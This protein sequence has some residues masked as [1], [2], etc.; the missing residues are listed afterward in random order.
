MPDGPKDLA[1]LSEAMLDAARAAGADAADALVVDGA[2]L[3]VDVLNGRLEQAERAEGVEIGLRVMV[4][5]GRPASRRPTRVPRPA[6]NGRTRRRHGPARARGPDRGPGRPGMLS[7]V[8]NADALDLEDPASDPSPARWRRCAPCRGRGAR[9]Q[10]RL[11]GSIRQR[12]LL[13]PPHSPCGKQRVFRRLRADSHG[14]SCVAITGEG[15]GMERDYFGDS[16][17]HAAD[18]MDPG[19]DRPHR[20]RAH[21]GTGRRA[22]AADRRLPRRLSRAHLLRSDRAPPVGHQRQRH[23][24]RRVLGAR[25]PGRTRPAKGPQPDRG[26]AAAPRRRVAPLRCRRAADRAAGSSWPTAS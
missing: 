18:L 24:T 1:T 19:G 26:S 6:R 4:G 13:A 17:T 22:Q 2:S 3:T 16:R 12:R 15:L 23:R 11:P 21:R 9:R 20:R 10:G 14:L 7:H 8:R 25:P 5:S